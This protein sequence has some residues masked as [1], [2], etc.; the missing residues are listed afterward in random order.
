AVSTFSLP[1]S[2]P[3]PT[4]FTGQS[5]GAISSVTASTITNSA[6][7]WSPGALSQAAS[8]YFIRIT[9]GQAVGRTLLISVSQANT[10][11]TA[12]VDNQGTA[13]DGL[14]IVAGDKY[15]VFP[16]YTLQTV[17][18]SSVL[19]GASADVSDVVRL[20]NG[21]GWVEYYY[22]STA[23]QWRQGSIPVTQNNV[24]VRPDSGIIFYRRGTSPIVLTLVGKVPSTDLQVVMNE[25][26]TAFVAG[27]PSASTI[28][29]NNYTTMPGWVNNTGS[30][31]D[32]DKVTA[33]V[34]GAWNSYNYNL[35][36]T[37]WRNGSV[38]V[39]QGAVAITA[40]TPVIIE[41]PTGT[42]GL[43]VWKRTLPYSLSAN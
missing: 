39:S 27:F 10:A 29:G 17:F 5:S 35:S 36:A 8:P 33:F 1:L 23:A 12:T 14:G 20:H 25:V 2:A 7:G 42:P 16:A 22:N 28:A 6:A 40:G 11:T 34:S 37:Q 24:V 21:T 19:G 4:N 26:G 15:E 41:S 9:S 31:T 3:V 43:K 13:L 30:V 18:G 38:P 32:S